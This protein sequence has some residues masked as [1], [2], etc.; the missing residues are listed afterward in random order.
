[1]QKRHQYSELPDIELGPALDRKIRA[2]TQAADR[3]IEE[4]QAKARIRSLVL[5]F[6]RSR[7]GLHEYVTKF[8]RRWDHLRNLAIENLAAGP[9]HRLFDEPVFSSMRA[10]FAADDQ[11]DFARDAAFLRSA[12]GLGDR[13][14]AS[15]KIKP[16][17]DRDDPIG[18]VVSVTSWAVLTAKASEE[19]IA[20]EATSRGMPLPV[21]EALST[22][23]ARE[24]AGANRNTST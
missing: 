15:G 13:R 12:R 17:Y 4:L 23:L 14:S 16:I 5:S 1:M 8:G 21:V 22:H 10:A 20:K 2:M 6:L 11:E 3:D 24:L 19:A 9:A 7:P 18:M